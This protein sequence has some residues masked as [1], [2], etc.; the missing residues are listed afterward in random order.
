MRNQKKPFDAA[1]RRVGG[2][3]RRATSDGRRA[4]GDGRRATGD[5]RRATTSLTITG[6]PPPI[7]TLGAVRLATG[8]TAP[9]GGVLTKEGSGTIFVVSAEGHAVTNHHVID[10]CTELRIEAREG[11]AKRVTEDTVNDLALVQIP[12]DAKSSAAIS[13][14]P[15]KLRQGDDIVVFGFPLNAILSSGG[16]LTPGVVSALT[17][18]GNNTNQIQITAPIQPGSSGS[19]VLTKKGEVV[20]VVSMKLSDSKMA[21]ATGSVGQNVNFATNG[22]TLRTFLDI[23]KVAYRSS[24]RFFSWDKSTTELAD[25][26]RKW[27]LV[28]ECWK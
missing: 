5:G 25:E 26:A 10:G 13:A 16:N 17:G 11:L 14:D 1:S 21:E 18:L 15:G 8:N 3:E 4:T 24:V 19:P 22:Q 12:G 20:G 6:A 28:V 2:A 27:T 23:N 9:A 7:T